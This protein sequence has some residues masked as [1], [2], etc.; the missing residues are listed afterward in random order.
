VIPVAHA[1]AGPLLDIVVPFHGQPTGE[2][3]S[4]IL[5]ISYEHQSDLGFHA[6]T[7]ETFAEALRKVLTLPLA[8]ELALRQRART[9]AVQRFSQEEFEKGWSESGWKKWLPL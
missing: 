9:W 7:P 4:S 3:M 5:S 8:E 6:T 1:S 2:S